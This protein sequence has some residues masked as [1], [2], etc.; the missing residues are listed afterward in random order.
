M[1]K[2]N[3]LSKR[4]IAIQELIKTHAIGDHGTLVELLQKNYTITTNQAAVSRDLRSLGIYKKVRGE[5][6][7]YEIP[8]TNAVAEILHYSIQS[9][10]HNETTIIIRTIA[11]TA[12]FVGD[13]LDMQHDLNFLGTIAGENTVL[14]V[15][16]TIKNIEELFKKVCQRLKIKE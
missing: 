12:S 13:F 8:T 11:G 3:K 15:P 4:K 5:T 1:I 10:H 16:H 6:M 14:I 7:I 2:D 9:A